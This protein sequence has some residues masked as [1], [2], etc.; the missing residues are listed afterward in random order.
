MRGGANAAA[1]DGLPTAAWSQFFEQ[2]GQ[3]GFKDLDRRTVN[4]ERQVRDNGVTYNVYADADGPQRPW[5]T[6][7]WRSESAAEPDASGSARPAR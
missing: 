6:S 1:R 2:L 7:C 4:L 5:S 3:D